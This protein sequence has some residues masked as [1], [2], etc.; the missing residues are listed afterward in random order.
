MLETQES[1]SI[2]KLDSQS[3]KINAVGK[4]TIYKLYE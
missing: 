3:Q 2:K 1:K 4:N